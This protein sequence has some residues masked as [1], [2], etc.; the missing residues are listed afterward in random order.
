MYL[1]CAD[2]INTFK[3]IVEQEHV[4]SALVAQVLPSI[5]NFEA[6]EVCKH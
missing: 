4:E 5:S 2:G 6:E 3:S 1:P